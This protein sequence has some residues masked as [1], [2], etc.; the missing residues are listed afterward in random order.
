M[1]GPKQ[2]ADPFIP[3]RVGGD[4]GTPDLGVHGA[5]VRGPVEATHRVTVADAAVVMRP[6]EKCDQGTPTRV[7]AWPVKALDHGAT[8][9]VVKRK[10]DVKILLS[11]INCNSDSIFEKPRNQASCRVGAVT[12]LVPA[13]GWKLGKPFSPGNKARSSPCEI[14][15]IHVHGG[16]LRVQIHRASAEHASRTR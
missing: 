16:R 5:P 9:L 10:L 13:W 14:P 8:T 2:L 11:A 12:H 4:P 15:C 7:G 6:W 1:C 3:H